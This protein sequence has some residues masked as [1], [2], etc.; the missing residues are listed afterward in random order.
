MTSAP[1][2]F[3]T[4]PSSSPITPA[5]MIRSFD[6]T[7]SSDSAP[8]DDTTRFSSISMPFSRAISEPVAMTMFL[9]STVCALPSLPVTS[10]L[11]APRILPL[12][13]MTSILFFFI[14]NSTPL[15]LPSMPC[16]LK[17][18]IDGRSSFG[19]ETLTPIL[20]KE[21]PASSNISE[22]C[23]SAFDGMQP[24]LRQVP[25]SVAFFSTTATFM[26][27]CAAR[28]AQTYPPGPVP[29]TTRS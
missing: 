2:R 5:P 10:T 7:F 19:A 28:T 24:T 4:E 13:L 8:V 20:A 29:M 26:P 15:T 25:P 27:S 17:F 23:S 18:I 1:S 14:R 16:C 21:C 3:Q 22:A 11:P 9:V 12:P 6:G